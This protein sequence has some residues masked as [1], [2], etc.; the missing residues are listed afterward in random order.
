M[1]SIWCRT[2]GFDLRLQPTAM[3][4]SKYYV[5]FYHTWVWGFLTGAYKNITE[6]KKILH[7]NKHYI[8]LDRDLVK[9]RLFYKQTHTLTINHYYKFFHWPTA[10]AVAGGSGSPQTSINTSKWG[11]NIILVTVFGNPPRAA[12]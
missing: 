4:R 7:G 5:I 9:L 2:H 1:L 10:A 6:T 12:S 11:L 8:I 3:R